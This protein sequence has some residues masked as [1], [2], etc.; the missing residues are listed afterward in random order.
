MIAPSVEPISSISGMTRN[1][2]SP[3]FSSRCAEATL[4]SAI[5]APTDR[6]MPPEMITRVRPME[7]ISRKALSMNR[8]KKVCA[9]RMPG[10]CIAP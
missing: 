9:L 8:L 2:L 1:G 4:V 10:Y 3:S 7:P 5:T 6:S